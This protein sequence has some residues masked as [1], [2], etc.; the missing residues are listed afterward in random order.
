M[1]FGWFSAHAE[2]F[3]TRKSRI[4]S[5]GTEHKKE[6]IWKC[7]HFT[8]IWLCNLH[9]LSSKLRYPSER[10]DMS[11]VQHQQS[12]DQQQ[13][14]GDRELMYPKSMDLF[15]PHSILLRFDICKIL[16]WIFQLQFF[17]KKNSR[18]SWCSKRKSFGKIKYFFFTLN[19]S[20]SLNYFNKKNYWECLRHLHLAERQKWT[21]NDSTTTNERYYHAPTMKQSAMSQRSKIDKEKK[22]LRSCVVGPLLLEPY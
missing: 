3:L 21:E 20:L 6:T 8:I 4:C 12:Y 15:H 11:R 7:S 9:Q 10:N 19:Q 18:C 22:F 5:A 13:V 17:E 1:L 14:Q 2:K 16:Y